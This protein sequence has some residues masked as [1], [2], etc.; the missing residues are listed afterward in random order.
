MSRNHSKLPIRMMSICWENFVNLRP[1][2][3]CKELKR[4]NFFVWGM[5]INR[6]LVEGRLLPN[7]T[8]VMT[9]TNQDSAGSCSWSFS[10]LLIVEWVPKWCEDSGIQVDARRRCFGFFTSISKIMVT[11]NE[12]TLRFRNVHFGSCF[13][14]LFPAGWGGKMFNQ[15]HLIK[16][17]HRP[18]QHPQWRSRLW[19]LSRQVAKGPLSCAMT[20]NNL[21]CFYRWGSFG[22]EFE[23]GFFSIFDVFWGINLMTSL[24]FQRIRTLIWGVKTVVL[25]STRKLIWFTWQW[26]PYPKKEMNRTWK[27]KHC[28]ECRMVVFRLM[29][30]HLDLWCKGDL[31][32]KFY[33]S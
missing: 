1:I 32:P 12:M 14:C 29:L 22:G 24:D 18:F 28:Q 33:R 7:F 15:K 26:T 10:F 30:A 9:L 23:G 16:T 17:Q 8:R 25:Y 2:S 4:R 31:L 3:C 5:A 21:A 11:M 19:M 6:R 20:W 13:R 27:L